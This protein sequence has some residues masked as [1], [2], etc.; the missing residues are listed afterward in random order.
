MK[1]AV[2]HTD[3]ACSGNP[4]PGG[5]GA[6]I[7]IDGMEALTVTGGDPHTTNSRME[8][9]A[10]IEAM[11]AI[12][13][14]S[15]V[16]WTPITVCSDSKYITDAF[17]QGWLENWQRNGWRKADKK[18]VANQDLW[19]QLVQEISPHTMVFN[20]VKGHSGDPMNERCDQ[21]AVAEAAFAP[22]TDGYWA[23]AGNRRSVVEDWSPRLSQER[24]EAETPPPTVPAEREVM[25]ILEA[26]SAAL[27]QCDNFASFRQRMRHVL[28][29]VEW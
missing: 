1:Q 8:L 24:P 14:M 15:G 23:S 5:F 4:G 27:D 19:T 6:I 25:R 17:N 29:E 26:M 21:L 10:V 3:G 2:I 12:N 18:P 20:W 7:V 22:R 11:R 28:D 9:S 13:S 16:E